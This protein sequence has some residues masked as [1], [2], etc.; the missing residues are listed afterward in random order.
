M[1]V[2]RNALLA[3]QHLSNEKRS[4]GGE[5]VKVMATSQGVQRRGSDGIW[6]WRDTE[7]YRTS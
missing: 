1:T 4:E 3:M 2:L 7:H 5:G 6:L